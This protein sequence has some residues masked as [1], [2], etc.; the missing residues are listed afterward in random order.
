[1]T[2]AAPSRILCVE[3]DAD[4]RRVA[5][6]ALERVGGFTVCMCR[7]G[8]EALRA[9]ADFRPDVILLDVMM[10]GMD[11]PTTLSR[12]RERRESRDI[13]AIFMTAK[14]QPHEIA[15]LK[16]AGALDVIAKPFD[17]M[18]LAQTVRT[19]F[20]ARQILPGPPAEPGGHAQELARI[21][22]EF[23]RRLPARV[24]EIVSLWQG[25]GA[26]QAPVEQLRSL[27]RAAHSLASSAHTFGITPVADAARAL[28]LELVRPTERS[29][30]LSPEQ[31]RRVAALIDALMRTA[32]QSQ[33]TP[34]SELL[35]RPGLL[36][37]AQAAPAPARL[38]YLLGPVACAWSADLR[39][40]LASCGYEARVLSDL[41]ALEVACRVHQPAAVLSEVA[42]P[43]WVQ[44]I[45]AM[46][47]RLPAP[48]AAIFVSERNDLD[49]RLQAAQ[50]GGAA[51]FSLP[52][53]VS[54]LVERLD[55]LTAGRTAEACRVMIVED[56]EEQAALYSAV[57]AQAGMSAC[58][59]ADPHRLLERLDEFHP[60]L[61]L[62]DMY[63]PQCSGADLAR[64][65]R[66]MDAHVSLPIVFLS[67][68]QDFDRQLAAMELGGDEFLTQPILPAQL[69]SVVESR[70]QRH[71]TLRALMVQDSLTGLA[72]HS[73]LHQL[74]ETEVARSLREGKPL[75]LAM[76][77]VD[78]FKQVNDRHGHPTGDRVLQGLAR[79]LRQRL[80]QSDAVGRYGGE[81][82]AV[83]MSNTDAATAAMVID[84]LRRHFATL[85]HESDSTVPFLVTFSAGVAALG[86]PGSTSARELLLNADRALYQ[87]KE[88]GRNCVVLY[89]AS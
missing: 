59:V 55:A 73:R 78:H 89:Q 86:P 50:A 68:E 49:T 80:R 76:I 46:R 32:E 61:I 48:P 2:T 58:V 85:V 47:Q 6:L 7:S 29:D 4:I 15:E 18:T 79:F 36:R 13:P 39:E 74:L 53:K 54:S 38:V 87:A 77:D 70:V 14:V 9:V 67:A 31:Q 60:E 21:A 66:Q 57:L 26:A 71:R 8:E 44:A 82:F 5:T 75:S 51:Y 41:G 72:N 19:I 17:P 10:P 34:P 63:L 33:P 11:G 1:M 27:H 28:E 84:R 3:D 16:R 20:S 22:Q 35:L 30:S 43:Q 23:V 56:A 83:V 62:M 81:E 37:S 25:A 64:V 42:S 88:T 40:Q 69:I 52:I 12:L 45:A 65:I 24:A